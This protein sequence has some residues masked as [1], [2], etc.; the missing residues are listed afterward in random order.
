MVIRS[1]TN[2]K[3]C[4]LLRRSGS[5][6]PQLISVINGTMSLIGPRPERPE[7]D[8]DLENL[9]PFMIDIA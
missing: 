4:K 5:T 6:N 3:R 9:I 2:H 8:E 1:D 7:F